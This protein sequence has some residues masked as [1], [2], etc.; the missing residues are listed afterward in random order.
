M[1]ERYVHLRCAGVA[2]KDNQVDVREARR[3]TH[4]AVI[5]D[6]GDRRTSGVQWFEYEA[7]ESDRILD[8][9][10]GFTTGQVDSGLKDFLDA[11]PN[12]L[13]IIAM[14]ECSELVT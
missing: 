7:S 12:G 8:G 13:L 4:D 3:L 6:L 10:D 5:D 2:D 9:L 1:S 14:A 11:S